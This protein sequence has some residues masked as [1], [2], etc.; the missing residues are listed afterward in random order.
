MSATQVQTI[1][2]K[3]EADLQLSQQG[4]LDVRELQV[5]AGLG[6]HGRHPNNCNKALMKHIAPPPLQA[7]LHV[8]AVPLK[9]ALHSMTTTCRHNA[10]LLP[11]VL[12]SVIF[13]EHNPVRDRPGFTT[14]AVPLSL[15]G[16]G[17]PVTSVGKSWGHSMDCFSWCSVVGRGSTLDFNFYIYSYFSKLRADGANR[18]TMKTVWQLICW[19]LDWLWRGQWPDRDCQGRMFA[20]SSAEGQRAL[21]PLAGG[22]FGTLWVLRGD[23]EYYGKVLG[24]NWYSSLKP[25]CLCDCNCTPG[26]GRAWS[27]FRP[28]HAEW[29][30]RSWTD[31]DWRVARQVRHQL[32]ELEGV[33]IDCVIADWMHIKHLG[34]DMYCFGSVLHLLCYSILPGG[35][36]VLPH[37]QH[38]HTVPG[39]TY[40]TSTWTRKWRGCCGKDCACVDARACD[41]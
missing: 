3:V 4:L 15:H 6:S 13:C 30:E 35:R 5:L 8:C 26:S 31:A 19:S 2:A 9:T 14:F 10:C 23:L 7:S 11:H 12:F 32:F 41:A 17:V 25:C 37:S 18:S 29:F 36:L 24:L 34:T 40:R 38:E 39:D 20:R 22:Y 28:G 21:S 27:E 33:G 1:A 16:D